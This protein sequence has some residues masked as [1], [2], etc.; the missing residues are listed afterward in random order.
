MK[1]SIQKR[2]FITYGVAI[3]IGFTILALSL[4]RIFDQYF[5]ENRKELLYEQ[6][7]K[8]AREAATVLYSGNPNS[9]SL[10]NDLQVLDR[11]LDAHIWVINSDGIIVAVSG[12]NEERLLGRQVR[13]EKIGNLA[14]GESI[15]ERGNFDGMLGESSLT[16]GYPVF[17]N[18]RFSGGVLVHASLLEIQENFREIYRLTLWVILISVAIAYAILYIQIRRIS[19]PL[20]EI[21]GAAKVIAGGEFHK[22]LNINTGDEIEELGNSFNN[23]AKSLEKIEEN[24]RNLI[25]NISHDLRSPMTSIR[26]FIEGMIDGTIPEDKREHYLNIVL[27][28]SNRLI[29]MTNELLELSNMQQ[30]SLEIKKEAFELNETIRRKLVAYEK[31]ITEKKLDVVFSMFEEKTFVLSDQTLLE[32]VLSNL[33]DNAVKFTPEKGSI[34]IRT[35]TKEDRIIVEITNTGK[36]ISSEELNRVWE[37]FHKGDTSRGLHKGGYGLGLAIV[38]EI[39]S[40]LGE[41]IWVSSGEGYVKFTLTIEKA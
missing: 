5:I 36:S 20:K 10:I 22:R 19:E 2:L 30:G 41:R 38:R 13:E 39:I 31:G 6:G 11:F 27:D 15:E 1:N 8:V 34:E 37:R 21:S 24:R 29:K 16:V 33:M 25:A 28:E 35:S 18:N 32:R 4:L 7:R 3:I 17:V 12:S 26:G 23:M 14:K 9:R 40:Q